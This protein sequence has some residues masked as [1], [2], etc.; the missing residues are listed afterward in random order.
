MRLYSSLFLPSYFA[1][2]LFWLHHIQ[3]S[4]SFIP[5]RGVGV[6]IVNIFW[7]RLAQEIGEYHDDDGA[8]ITAEAR[9]WRWRHMGAAASSTSQHNLSALAASGVD[10]VRFAASPYCP[11]HFALYRLGGRS[12]ER[13]WEILLSIVRE[14]EE[15]NVRLIPTIMWRAHMLPL[16]CGEP[17]G[18]LFLKSS[19]SN[20]LLF[21]YTTQLVWRMAASKAVVAWELMNEMDLSAGI[22]HAR[23]SRHRTKQNQA[24]DVENQGRRRLN[25][26][27][28]N[29]Y[30]QRTMCRRADGGIWEGGGGRNRNNERRP[31]FGRLY[32]SKANAGLGN[33]AALD[34]STGGNYYHESDDDHPSDGAEQVG[35]QGYAGQQC[36]STR[37]EDCDCAHGSNAMT[38][39][40]R[41]RPASQ[42]FSFMEMANLE[43]AWAQAIRRVEL[44]RSTE[45]E[46]LQQMR[47]SQDRAAAVAVAAAVR[48]NHTR[49]SLMKAAADAAAM[50]TTF[51]NSNV[52]ARPST[53]GAASTF[54]A[55]AEAA[56]MPPVSTQFDVSSSSASSSSPSTSFSSS[57]S[58]S[59][60]SSLRPYFASAL[61]PISS[62]HALPRVQAYHLSHSHAAPSFWRQHQHATPSS[63]GD[64]WAKD[65]LLQFCRNLLET[66]AHVELASIHPCTSYDRNIMTHDHSSRC[67]YLNFLARFVGLDTDLHSSIAKHRSDHLK[68]SN[69][70][71][72]GKLS[73]ERQAR[74]RSRARRHR[75]LTETDKLNITA[76]Q[77]SFRDRSLP[78]IELVKYAQKCIASNPAPL[79]KQLYI[80][81]FGHRQGDPATLEFVREVLALAAPATGSTGIEKLQETRVERC[82][83]QS[84]S[85]CSSSTGSARLPSAE[86]LVPPLCTI[87]VL[88]FKPQSE[89]LS[90]EFGRDSSLLAEIAEANAIIRN[91]T[92]Y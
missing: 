5:L 51:I 10:L 3:V 88:E 1:V 69:T 45:E 29:Q 18:S 6:N 15:A 73:R 44:T 24:E 14:A 86:A 32:H 58:S 22:N 26:C 23:N 91:Q 80:G 83:P 56:A 59:S 72:V 68:Q 41:A 42:D 28:W 46:S 82:G 12:R 54:D 2:L 16:S 89:T 61:R 49:G 35:E 9:S 77:V 47:R 27:F 38:A 8:N 64:R 67:L 4:R 40:T 21:E 57:S 90:I 17:M 76:P 30:K 71:F 11:N 25:N 78:L 63:V 50:T 62:G 36:L 81:E 34:G 37:A 70:S 7:E 52:G 31:A 48:T 92:L 66:H 39:E 75:R 74:P 55:A 79:P 65:S 87:W 85:G 43:K 19:C 60:S 20:K 53:I 13:Y 33:D 84:S